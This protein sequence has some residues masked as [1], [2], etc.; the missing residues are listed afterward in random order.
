MPLPIIFTGTMLK[1][2][3]RGMLSYSQAIQ[4]TCSSTPQQNKAA[5]GRIDHHL[6]KVTH[7]LI[8]SMP[9]LKHLWPLP[10][11]FMAMSHLV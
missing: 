7:I 2:V 5:K 9:F 1:N 10:Q 6:L 4:N 8:D 3:S 11:F